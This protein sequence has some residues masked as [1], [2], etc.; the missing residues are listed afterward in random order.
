VY[1]KRGTG[2]FV[3]TSNGTVGEVIE[4]Q[5]KY[6]ARRRLLRLE[7]GGQVWVHGQVYDVEKPAASHGPYRAAISADEAW[8]AELRRLFGKRA[9]DVRY[10]PKGAGAP[11][12][13]LR[14]LHDAKVAADADLFPR[15]ALPPGTTRG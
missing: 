7:G 2:R 6:G 11:G 12:S 15:P 14:R 3:R 8:G 1:Q 13:E 5:G 9:G 10:T 4:E